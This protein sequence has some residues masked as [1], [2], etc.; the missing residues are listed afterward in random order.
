MIGSLLRQTLNLS[1]VSFHALEAGIES[2]LI[3]RPHP[4]SCVRS[5]SHPPTM[6]TG[7]IRNPNPA[8]K[9]KG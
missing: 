2:K 5:P 1:E 4:R 7:Q 8:P 6:L 9:R 3:N